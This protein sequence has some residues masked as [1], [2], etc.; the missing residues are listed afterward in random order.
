MAS[1]PPKENNTRLLLES[2]MKMESFVS[3]EHEASAKNP[4]NPKVWQ[5]SEDPSHYH[6]TVLKDKPVCNN[7][8]EDLY[9]AS[10]A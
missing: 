3:V 7:Q 5:S 8:Y 1:H 6:N 4:D 9:P 10:A 2:F